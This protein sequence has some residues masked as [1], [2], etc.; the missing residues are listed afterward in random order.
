[1]KNRTTRSLSL[2]K[3]INPLALTEAD[4]ENIVLKVTEARIPLPNGE[5]ERIPYKKLLQMHHAA[6]VRAELA[7]LELNNLEIVAT[8]LQ[9]V[10]DDMYEH[11]L[12]SYLSDIN[13]YSSAMNAYNTYD[14]EWF[15][16]CP[17]SI[18]RKKEFAQSLINACTHYNTIS[19]FWTD[20]VNGSTTAI[21]LAQY[22]PTEE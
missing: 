8:N 10:V 2:L 14:A 9:I 12:N 5:G 17:V 19:G 3:H 15:S 1:M 16:A 7:K 22:T 18:S 4:I 13:D 21:E 11:K 20:L 6:L